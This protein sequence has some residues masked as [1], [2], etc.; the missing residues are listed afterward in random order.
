MFQSLKLAKTAS[1]AAPRLDRRALFSDLGY[2]PH[3]GQ[4]LVHESKARMRVVA[5]GVRWGK[6][7]SAAMEGIAASLEPRHS[8]RGWVVAPTY[9]LADKVFRELVQIAQEHLGPLVQKL[10]EAERYLRLRN[11]S[12]GT[13]ELWAK[14]ADNPVSLLGE[15]LDWC[16]CDEAARL[17]PTIWES[18]LSQRLID[19]QGWSLLISTPKGKGWFYDLW[20]RGQDP[21]QAGQ[22]ESWNAPTWQNPIIDRDEV[23]RQRAG[24]PERVFRQEYGGEFIEGAGAVF[25]NV[26]EC[27][28]LDPWPLDPSSRLTHDWL[29]EHPDPEGYQI[30][31]DLA[32]VEDYTVIA[33]TDSQR[34]L[35]YA[36][37]WHRIDWA[38][39]IWR[40]KEVFDRYGQPPI[41]VDSTGVGEPVYEQLLRAGLRC[42]PYQFTQRSKAALIDNLAILL[43]RRQCELP[44]PQRWPVGIEE[45]ESFEYQI[46]DAGNAKQ[47]APPGYHDDCVIACALAFWGRRL[48]RADAAD[49]VPMSERDGGLITGQYREKDEPAWRWPTLWIE[50]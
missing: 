29:G 14:T 33:V 15:G 23:E 22:A 10:S 45:L 36:D 28:T 24:I 13:S 4:V 18:Y 3:P 11:M 7:R 46:T 41:V 31:L 17:R 25:R 43:E 37:R 38:Q 35:V 5:C 39:Q 48:D 50:D 27:A 44:S 1:P 32:K 47:S 26:R 30:G 2:Y 6:T 16:I 34:R 12:G 40:V 9:T 20:R 49:L 21:T 42:T 19:R 8:T